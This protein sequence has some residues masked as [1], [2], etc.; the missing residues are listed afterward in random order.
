MLFNYETKYD[1]VVR[2]IHQRL[3]TYDLKKGW[4]VREIQ[5]IPLLN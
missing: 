4:T 2:S 3:I 5:S 1:E